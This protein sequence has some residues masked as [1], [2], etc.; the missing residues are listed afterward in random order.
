MI[1][2]ST[3]L[4]YIVDSLLDERYGVINR[5]IETPYEQGE[6]AFFQ[7]VAETASTARWLARKPFSYGGGASM[8]RDIAMAKAICECVERYCSAIYDLHDFH[9]TTARKATFETVSPDSFVL[10]SSRQYEQKG[11][12]YE[13]FSYDAYVRWVET[14]NLTTGQSIWV[15]AALVYLPYYNESNDEAMIAPPISTGLATGL[16]LNRATI[17]AILEV[18]ERDAFC[19]CWY[20]RLSPVH[21]KSESLPESIQ[22]IVARFQ[23]AGYAVDILNITT[24]LGIPVIMAIARGDRPDAPAV[25]VATSASLFPFEAITK[26]LEELAMTLR[27]QREL[28]KNEYKNTGLAGDM[29]LKFWNDRSR[30]SEAEFLWNNKHSIDFSELHVGTNNTSSK[31][32]LDELVSRLSCGGFVCLA[33]EI[34][35][36]DIQQLGL[37][38]VRALVPGLQP[39]WFGENMV[40]QGGSRLN[41]TEPNPLLHPFP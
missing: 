34:T 24:D 20:E 33:R 2:Q 32:T 21:L 9:L 3:G 27:Y 22:K 28:E 35:S 23:R 11:M 10:F 12:P 17:S 14:L 1:K 4:R 40:A 25:S 6:P 7:F 31:H 19:K 37:S 36:P 15:P 13:C 30:R 39:L 5:V 38:V 16:D 18:V 29:H 8:S 26:S 41:C